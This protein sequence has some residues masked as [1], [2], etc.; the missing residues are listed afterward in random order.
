MK[1]LFLIRH[2]KSSWANIDLDDFDRPLN[3][4]GKRDAPAMAKRLKAK[5]VFPD[6]IVTSAAKRARKTAQKFAKVLGY[7][8][9]KIYSL[10]KL[11]GCSE[12]TLLEVLKNT[13][14]KV[15]VLFLIGHNPELN[16]LAEYLVGFD[17]NIVTSGVVS[18]DFDVAKWDDISANNAK[19]VFYD[20]P[21]LEVNA[22]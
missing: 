13:D 5:G 3:S 6:M 19:F 8:K 9:N 17:E 15:K 14:D 22:F 11:Y 7:D 21:K 1:K 16:E 20:F 12:K 2:A 18:I 10:E 4:R